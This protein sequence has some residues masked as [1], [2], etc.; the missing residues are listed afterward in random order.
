MYNLAEKMIHHELQVAERNFLLLLEYNNDIFIINIVE[1]IS[2]YFHNFTLEPLICFSYISIKQQKE[3]H[4]NDYENNLARSIFTSLL[5]I[6]LVK[7]MKSTCNINLFNNTNLIHDVC[8]NI[9][10]ILYLKSSQESKKIIY[11]T[12]VLEF[13]KMV[14]KY[15]RKIDVNLNQVYFC[16]TDLLSKTSEIPKDINFLYSTRKDLGVIIMRLYHDTKY[17]FG[18]NF[19]NFISEKIFLPES[20]YIKISS[21]KDIVICSNWITNRINIIFDIFE[22]PPPFKILVY[23][24]ELNYLYLDGTL[25]SFKSNLDTEIPTITNILNN[26]TNI[27]Y[28]D[29]DDDKLKE[30]IKAV[31]HNEITISYKQK[32]V[33]ALVEYYK[34][35]IL[36]YKFIII[37]ASSSLTTNVLEIIKTFM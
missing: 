10:S 4:F 20:K 37:D 22:K 7:N 19:E 15:Y 14:C 32:N 3:C 35:D 6:S 8:G 21:I 2:K 5:L 24:N 33:N 13:E 16:F 1:D 31:L 29:I 11:K 17:D 26:E 36:L 34:F 12:I 27:N 18:N 25:I 9:N 28:K 30:W 23:N